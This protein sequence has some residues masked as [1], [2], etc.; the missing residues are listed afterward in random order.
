MSHALSLI[1]QQDLNLLTQQGLL[2]AENQQA[3]VVASASIPAMRDASTSA[4]E[5]RFARADSVLAV[6][7]NSPVDQARDVL[8]ALDGLWSGASGEFHR[9]RQIHFDIK[10][11]QVKIDKMKKTMNLLSEDDRDIR[12]AEV[13]LAEAELDSGL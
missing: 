11:R 8:S 4:G 1:K 6:R 10:L 5:R 2:S 9:L 13:A 12:E 3:L 7:S